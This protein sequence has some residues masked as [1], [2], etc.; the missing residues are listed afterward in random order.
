MGGEGE[1]DLWDGHNLHNPPMSPSLY[2]VCTCFRTRRGRS[3]VPARTKVGKL[4]GC[5]AVWLC[6]VYLCVSAS[7][8]HC[9]CLVR[10]RTAGT[11]FIASST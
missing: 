2:A 8:R 7:L 6:C 11:P 1:V 3:V 9:L 4:P 5:V 10:S